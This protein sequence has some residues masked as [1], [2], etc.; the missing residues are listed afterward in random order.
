MKLLFFVFYWW[1]FNNSSNYNKRIYTLAINIYIFLH[2]KKLSFDNIFIHF[3]SKNLRS[4][5]EITHS[6]TFTFS[7]GIFLYST[8]RWYLEISKHDVIYQLICPVRKE[9]ILI[10]F[11]SKSLSR[12]TLV[13]GNQS[14]SRD[15][16]TNIG[17][18]GLDTSC[19]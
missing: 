15:R 6:F 19:Y 17:F 18:S 7:N 12:T 2:L 9:E 14:K 1:H 4:T 8:Y 5:N 10:S 3:C 13:V 16:R 11:L